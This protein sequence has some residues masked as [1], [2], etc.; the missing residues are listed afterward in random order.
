MS[1]AVHPALPGLPLLDRTL[2]LGVLNVT[3]DSFSDGGLF[4]AH[5][6]AVA[7]G[8]LLAADGADLV[9]VGGE[10]TRPGAARVCAQEELERVLPVVRRLAAA[11][12]LVSIDTTRAS[13]AAAAVDAGA[14][15][16][17]DVSGGRGDAN[18][19]ALI[20]SRGVA[21]VVM[22]SRGTSTDMQSLAVYT[23]VVAEVRDELAARVV[24]LTAAGVHLEQ[25]VLDP[26]IGFAKTA[27][28]NVQL[29]ASLQSLGS[30]LLVGASRKSFLGSLLDG[31]AVDDREDATQAIT[32]VCAW[33]GIWGVRVHE[34]RPAAD[35]VRVVA[36]LR[37][38]RP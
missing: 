16:V 12:V 35:A 7:H 3:P 24:A 21:Y 32:A 34:A 10:S 11:G 5:D 29:L 2:V 28:H 6:A 20:A 13:V 25:I 1:S 18:M 15:L 38:A 17:N 9:D 19:P 26:G 8:L 23:D 30:P 37:E 27:E 31:R 33:E 4:V 36:A 14:V 22:H